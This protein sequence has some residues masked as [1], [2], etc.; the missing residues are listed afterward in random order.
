MTAGGTLALCILC[1]SELENTQPQAKQHG[2]YFLSSEDI[3]FIIL[4]L[5]R[6]VFFFMEVNN[7]VFLFGVFSKHNALI[8][9]ILH[10]RY[11]LDGD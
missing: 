3:S 2:E 6:V 4:L 10:I 5:A 11:I 7:A 9:E 8:F 1:H